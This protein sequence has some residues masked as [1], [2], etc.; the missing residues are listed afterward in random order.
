[1]RRARRIPT[2]G[3]LIQEAAVTPS[4]NPSATMPAPLGDLSAALAAL[5]GRV[6]GAVVSVHS[7][8]A[9]SSGFVWRPNLIVTADEGLAEEGE[10]TVT[11]PGGETI[12]ARAVGRDPTTDVALLRVERPGLAPV[13]LVPPDASPAAA[14]PIAAGS[15]VLAVGAE[16]GAPTAALGVVSRATGAWRSLRGG[17]IDARIEADL[18]LRRSAEGGLVLDASGRPIGMAAFGPRRRVLVIP[19]ATIERVAPKLASG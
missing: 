14:P 18:R 7:H 5:V 15:L 1:M 17:E 12:P 2:L 9:R 10:I 8:R 6:A 3:Q 16:E 19:A 4:P 13:A 11:V